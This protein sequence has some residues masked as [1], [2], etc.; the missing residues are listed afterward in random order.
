MAFAAPP[1]RLA[2]EAI[3]RHSPGETIPATGAD[4]ARGM[5]WS[6][7]PR[8]GTVPAPTSVPSRVRKAEISF[9][10]TA[11]AG[12]VRKAG[13]SFARTGGTNRVRKAEISFV[14][15]ARAGRVRKTGTASVPKDATSR[16]TLSGVPSRAPTSVASRDRKSGAGG[17]SRTR[18]LRGASGVL[19]RERA[20]A[21][22]RAPTLTAV[23]RHRR[24]SGGGRWRRARAGVPIVGRGSQTKPGF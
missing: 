14:R 16:A 7:A 3:P 19:W 5:A 23:P 10:R 9:V 17:A 22:S 6:S 11:R 18:P 2:A 20:P 4:R 24:R 8:A 1:A 13:P 15:T 21:S 12:R